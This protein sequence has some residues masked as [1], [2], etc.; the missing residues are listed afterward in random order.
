ML[1]SHSIPSIL[2]WTD[3]CIRVQNGVTIENSHTSNLNCIDI[4][5]QKSQSEL[6]SKMFPFQNHYWLTL[7]WIQLCHHQVCIWLSPSV[8][9][10]PMATNKLAV[11]FVFYDNM[12]DKEP[13]NLKEGYLASS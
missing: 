8:D 11:A 3:T 7:G 6:A 9:C 1:R 12:Y 10:P 5:I 2:T 13:F 4:V